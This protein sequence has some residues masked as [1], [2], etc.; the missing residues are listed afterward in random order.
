[1]NRS[2]IFIFLPLI[3]LTS[4]SGASIRKLM[5]D[6]AYPQ[7]VMEKATQ[8]QLIETDLSVT[9]DYELGI[10]TGT[11]YYKNEPLAAYTFYLA[12]VLVDQNTGVEIST[13]L[14]RS[15]APRTITDETGRLEFLNV[16]PGRYGLTLLDGI[17]TF[18][19]LNPIDGKPILI[20]METGANIELGKFDYYDLPIE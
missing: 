6:E 17:N 7:P 14:D 4:C 12:E 2:F 5:G 11:V 18:L 1:M 3:L 19:L 16:P 20:T 8:V 13:A 9:P 10:V 15:T